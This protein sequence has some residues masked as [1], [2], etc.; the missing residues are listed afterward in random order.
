MCS[1]VRSNNDVHS[2]IQKT[3][4]CY[5][6]GRL[7]QFKQTRRQFVMLMTPAWRHE[8]AI[9][10]FHFCINSVWLQVRREFDNMK[11]D[12]MA[13]FKWCLKRAVL[14]FSISAGFIQEEAV[15]KVTRNKIRWWI[16]RRKKNQP[17]L[18]G[19]LLTSFSLN[20]NHQKKVSLKEKH[21]I[22]QLADIYIYV[23][24]IEPYLFF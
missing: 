3:F 2:I 7:F 16:N 13:I 6:D 21:I 8:F 18:K 23:A 17:A 22:S 5:S 12:D 15:H 14:G 19:W 20:N 1:W 11:F 9:W 4:V 10:A 24:T